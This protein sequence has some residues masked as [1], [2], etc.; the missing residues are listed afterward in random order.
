MPLAIEDYLQPNERIVCTCGAVYA[1][2]KRLIHY[3]PRSKS[4]TFREY[5]YP[6]ITALKLV[7]KARFSTV[8]LGFIVTML[9]FLTGPGSPFQIAVAALGVA[10]MGMGFLLGDRYL[11]VAGGTDAENPVQWRLRDMSH[12]D[13]R[14]FVNVVR[15]AMTAP[16]VFVETTKAIVIAASASGVLGAVPKSVLLVPADQPSQVRSALGSAANVVCL[17]M[18]DL[19]HPA[20]QEAARLMAW[21]E[22]TAASQTSKG[23]WA[24]IGVGSNQENLEACVWP[25]LNAVVATVGSAEGVQQLEAQLAALEQERGVKEQVRIVVALDTAAAVWAVRETL[26]ASPRVMA[27]VVGAHDLL[28]ASDSTLLRQT[29]PDREYMQGRIVAGATES[30]VP[31]LGMIGIDIAPGHL[32]EVLGPDSEVRL[33]QAALTARDD[34]FK[35]V[36][37]THVEVAAQCNATF[38][39]SVAKL[40]P[41]QP[42]PPLPA[43]FWP[44][45]PSYFERV[46]QEPRL[47]PVKWPL[48]VP[49]YFGVKLQTPPPPPTMVRPVVSA[50]IGGKSQE[51]RTTP[52]K[53]QPVVPSHFQRA[54]PPP[55]AS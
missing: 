9:S 45:V 17:D 34:S 35:G 36:V 50:H 22:V 2:D 12:K 14:E 53:W 49:S 26:A 8:V 44:V 10:A 29:F 19:V 39:G 23:V 27:T 43:K 3:T 38:P 37:T 25:G 46:K 47:V 40:T 6:Q 1:T 28:S 7:P 33:A 42:P 41:L 31:M 51:P 52:V 11:E 30:G 54:T 16:P 24:H 20:N 4:M 15:S 21:G 32:S 13:S 48:V 18:T 55:D 5:A